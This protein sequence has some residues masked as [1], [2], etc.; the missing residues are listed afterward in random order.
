M[1]SSLIIE[2]LRRMH[3]NPPGCWQLMEELRLGTGFGSGAEQR[4]DLFAIS[5]WP[6][7][8]VCPFLRRAFE[9]KVSRGDLAA[10]LRNSDKRYMA[11][12]HSHE[13][14]FAAPVG[15]IDPSLIGDD[16]LVEVDDMANS[17]IVKPSK[18]RSGFEPNWA[19]VASICRKVN[20][21]MQKLHNGSMCAA[22]GRTAC[23]H[24]S[25]DGL[26]MTCNCGNVKLA[27]PV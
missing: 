20:E 1:K 19:L 8:G 2:A 9:V 24:A 23:W 15:L 16:G 22:C 12:V 17:T 5:T 4:I 18:T 7:N 14:Y 26:S 21:A 27:Q 6:S 10:E 25:E 11:K 13:F 3:A